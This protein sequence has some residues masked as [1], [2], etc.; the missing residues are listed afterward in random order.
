MGVVVCL[1]GDVGGGGR[2]G[3]AAICEGGR[4]GGERTMPLM[5]TVVNM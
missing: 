2:G 5:Y 4:E 1:R 3:G